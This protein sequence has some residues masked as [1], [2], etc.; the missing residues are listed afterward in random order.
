MK[1][2]KGRPIGLK[3]YMTKDQMKRHLL[4]IK[5]KWEKEGFTKNQVINA[6]YTKCKP[7]GLVSNFYWKR[8]PEA[9]ENLRQAWKELGWV[10][11]ETIMDSFAKLRSSL[12]NS[13]KKTKLVRLKMPK[14]EKAI[15]DYLNQ[16]F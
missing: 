13:K 2:L 3:A 10:E 9:A 4:K 16:F 6:I 5:E 11:N 15:V 14:T 7:L 12:E 1:T 8:Y